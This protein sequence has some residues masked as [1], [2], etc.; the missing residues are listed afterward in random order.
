MVVTGERIRAVAEK[1]E[2]PA[3]TEE[4]DGTGKVLLP[5]LIDSHVHVL[6][7]E[8][9]HQ[10]AV[11]G[12][13]TAMDM[14]SP[15]AS[16]VQLEKACITDTQLAEL[17]M[18]STPATVPGG[19]GTEYG[20]P[21]P[22]L[23]KP[24]EARAFVDARLAEGA[25]YIKII[26]D[27]LSAYGGHFPTLDKPTLEAV[28]H[29]AHER[30]KMA[31]VHIGSLQAAREAIEAGADGL[32]HT[33]EDVAPDAELGAF[34]A[35]HRAFVVPTLSLL[36]SVAGRTDGAELSRDSS[37][38]P[39]LRAWDV[40]NLNT[41]FPPSWAARVKYSHAEESVRAF[42]AARVPLLVGTDAPNPGT[43]YGASVH[44]ELELLVK[45][46]L[47]PTEALTAATALPAQRFHLEDRGRIQPGL[48][49]DLLLVEGDPTQDIRMTRKIDAVWIRGTK[50]ER[51]EYQRAATA[52]RAKTTQ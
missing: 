46:G 52:D 30:G 12:V 22:T 21:V 28:I 18:A 35:A 33:F 10:M 48:R 3:G 36:A 20:F 49:A 43:T 7:A 19:H 17:H 37:I 4:R 40:K 15:A 14:M 25:E 1:A 16:A 8:Q 44:G 29:A 11:L 13:T 6:N 26:Y 34:V 42:K 38:A 23:T 27:D 9:L 2:V 47:T 50:V 41:P 51:E 31:I 32:S 5:G 45:A 24:E 39:F